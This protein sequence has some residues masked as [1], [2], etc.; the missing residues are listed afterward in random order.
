MLKRK[1]AIGVP[2]AALA[3]HTIIL[4]KTRAGK[5]STA[6][7]MVER[8]LDQGKPVCI[9][10]P[11]GDWWGLKSSSDGSRPGYPVVI[12]GG[13]H[14][15]VPLNAHSGKEV[16]ELVASGNRPCIID[17]RGWKVSERTQF[18]IDFAHGLFRHTRGPRHLIIDEVHNF[19]PQGKVLSPQ[20]GEMLHWANRLASEG[21]GMGI[22]LI[23]ASQRPQKV[24]KDY[25]TCHETLVAMRVIHPLDR[26]SAK[27]W[28]DGCPDREKGR[29]VLETLATMKRGEAWV[30]SPEI[31]FGPERIQFPLF[32]TYDSFKAPTGEGVQSLKGWAEVDLEEVK[33][34][35]AAAVEEAKA[36]DPRHLK[37]E[38]A[39]L[40]KL[41]SE[42]DKNL[43]PDP[44]AIE[45]ARQEGYERG[46][47]AG[48]AELKALC[49]DAYGL[50]ADMHQISEA[51][52]NKVDAAHARAEKAK[53]TAPR[54]APK[55]APLSAPQ[56]RPSPPA[57]PKP[58][59]QQTGNNGNLSG[60]QQKIIDALAWWAALGFPA[61]T[62]TQLA[63]VAGYKPNTGT[64]NT[65][66]GA[67]STAGLIEYPQRGHV[68]LT[69][70]GRSVAKDP[71]VPS[72]A[73]LRQR[74][75]GILS[76]PQNRLL[77]ALT[78]TW[79]DPLTR[80]ELAERA[81]YQPNTG[82][83]NT[84]LGS[85]STLGIVDYPERGQVRAQDWLF[86]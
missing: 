24:H 28:I 47:E 66:L 3:H 60:P 13:D 42:S 54:T 1:D 8:L 4:G 46:W 31:D 37:S 6:R 65:Y 45:A 7:I 44:Q 11:K 84:Y 36:N 25:V 16:A 19:A 38:I 15:D 18:F 40:N 79:P 9:L 49:G 14:A 52:E 34:K 81:G 73:E 30:W 69:G 59:A 33:E 39:R 77:D 74:V 53:P 21:A 41:L 78:E 10:D 29:E 50:I 35:L 27:E 57:T 64:F 70:E 43:Q 68:G 63:F 20:A 17:L 56:R 67:L 82:T 5:S 58:V 62:R 83:F 72:A 32:R 75:S 76:G 86:P 55:A 22:T 12:F 2:D 23:S 61:P 85:L 80:Q 26:G 51:F 71:G 48:M